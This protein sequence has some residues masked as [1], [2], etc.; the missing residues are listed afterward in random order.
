MSGLTDMYVKLHLGAEGNWQSSDTHLRASK[1]NGNFN[2]RY[3]F[4]ITL[5]LKGEQLV[6]TYLTMQIWD[7][8][9]V[10]D[11]LLCEHQLNLSDFLTD[12]FKKQTSM[13]FKVWREQKTKAESG[14]KQG[15]DA[16][17]MDDQTETY[18]CMDAS[19]AAAEASALACAGQED[20]ETRAGSMACDA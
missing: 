10:Y 8:D 5:P 15:Y 12:A 2:W 20:E 6:S 1:G 3:K 9:M 19:Q 18:S 17:D 4:P 16:I 11:D 7:M 14:G 13:Q